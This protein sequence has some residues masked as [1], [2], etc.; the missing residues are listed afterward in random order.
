MQNETLYTH[1]PDKVTTVHPNADNIIPVFTAGI[2]NIQW[3]R[4]IIHNWTP[5]F[6]IF[7]H[8]H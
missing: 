5:R 4:S 7:K 8:D 3:S 6:S 1:D 2:I